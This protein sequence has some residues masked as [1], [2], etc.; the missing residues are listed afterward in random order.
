MQI[1]ETAE[2]LVNTGAAPAGPYAPI[3]GVPLSQKPTS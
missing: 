2:Q 1:D 3:G